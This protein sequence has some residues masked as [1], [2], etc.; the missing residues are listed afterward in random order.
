M[1]RKT[2][3]KIGMGQ[4][5]V[6]WSTT[7]VIFPQINAE[8]VGVAEASTLEMALDMLDKWN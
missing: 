4:M 2:G 3:Y 8:S 7:P 1:T 5:T 6:L